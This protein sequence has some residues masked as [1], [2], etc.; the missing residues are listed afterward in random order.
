LVNKMPDLPPE[1]PTMGEAIRMLARLGGFL[2]RKSDGEPGTTTLWR[3]LQRLKSGVAM[4]RFL[5]THLRDG[6]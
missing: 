1:V 6:P 4:Y 5:L 3:G 2:V